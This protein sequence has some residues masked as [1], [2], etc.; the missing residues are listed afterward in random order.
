M[1]SARRRGD[2]RLW[3]NVVM[4]G[5]NEAARRAAWTLVPGEI[6]QQYKPGLL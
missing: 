1:T 6:A 4:A 5:E 2:I 3:S